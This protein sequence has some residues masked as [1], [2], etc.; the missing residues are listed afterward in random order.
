M[1][2]PICIRLSSV[3]V[4]ELYICTDENDP[5]TK[6]FS[7][8]I[9]LPLLMLLN[10]C[11]HKDVMSDPADDVKETIVYK[12]KEGSFVI[13]QEQI[14][15]ATSKS[16][17]RGVSYTTGYNE[18]RLTS[19]DIGTGA[20]LG[21]VELGE[22]MEAACNIIAVAEGQLWMYSIDPELGLHCRNPKTL[23]V[24]KKEADVPQLKGF[25]FARPE[26]TRITDYYA[27]DYDKKRMLI[28]DL[29]GV[30]YVFDPSKSALEKT[31]DDMPKSD[32][33]ED[34]LNSSAYF[35]KE[36]YA[37]FD[38]GDDRKK[39]VWKGEASTGELSFLRPEFFVDRNP[40]R[41]AQRKREYFNQLNSKL[42]SL[43]G[44]LA[45]IVKAHPIFGR[46]EYVSYDEYTSAEYEMKNDVSNI[47]YAIRD[48]ESDI[49]QEKTF[50]SDYNQ[51]A[52]GPVA[53]ACLVYSANNVSDTARAVIT[54]VDMNGKKFTQRWMLNL[55][56]LYFDPDKAESAGVFDEG[57]PE[58]GYRWAD[59]QE[60]K[61]LMIAQLKMICIDINSG[62]LLWEIS[63]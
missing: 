30:H 15:Q 6:R 10:S 12:G 37:S 20:I 18:C 16:S 60:G 8:L 3:F 57:N 62:K 13:T 55:P 47:K 27:Y 5:M 52:L 45:A 7:L 17:G 1:D 23:E 56:S 35:D 19:Y 25:N 44:A 48:V 21:R 28:T 29:Q 54:L 36:I 46:E 9:L 38:G 58:F 14:F 22:E 49:Q 32:W 31:D 50:G 51:Y 61:F 39:M 40:V 33:H 53:N 59:I 41:S 63:L 34:Y 2:F 43:K 4:S 26:W 24:I 11:F 42:D